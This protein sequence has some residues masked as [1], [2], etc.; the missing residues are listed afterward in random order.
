MNKIAA[1]V[2]SVMTATTIMIP[3]ATLAKDY[4]SALQKSKNIKI[5]RTTKGKINSKIKLVVND[6]ELK[7]KGI[8]VNK[9]VNGKNRRY[10]MLPAES[11]AKALGYKFTLEDYVLKIDTGKV[12]AVVTL[13][14]DGTYF[15]DSTRD[16]ITYQG[17]TKFGVKPMKVKG[18]YYIPS[19][20]FKG[21][22]DDAI[23]YKSL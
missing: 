1:G 19:E 16:W 21:L 23:P 7:E 13:D 2:L 10:V 18:K 14:S 5:V 4:S 9:K 22:K 11:M 15:Y 6:N 3:S 17:A 8:I 12:V 20:I